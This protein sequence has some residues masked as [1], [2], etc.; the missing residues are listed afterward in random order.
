VKS[1]ATLEKMQAKKRTLWRRD[2]LSNEAARY[3]KRA[4]DMLGVRYP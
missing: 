3:S 2:Y 4:A 1:L